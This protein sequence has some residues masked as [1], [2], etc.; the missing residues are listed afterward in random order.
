MD[1]RIDNL[2]GYLHGSLDPRARSEFEGLLASDAETRRMVEE[3]QR[4]AR[5]MRTL[6]AD[7]ELD[8]RA[9]FYGRVMDRIEAQRGSTFWSLFLEPRFFQRLAFASAALLVL[10]AALLVAPSDRSV[11]ASGPEHIFAQD[12]EAAALDVN[13]E[14]Q[15]RN[16]D[17][18]LGTLTTYGE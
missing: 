5:A 9:G 14:H 8:P 16:R 12:G 6:R 3:F 10:M 17:T 13:A 15:D 7:G 1:R 2:E 4:H 11:V 18:V